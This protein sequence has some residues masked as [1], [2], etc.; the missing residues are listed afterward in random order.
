MRNPYVTYL[1]AINVG[2]RTVE[3]WCDDANGY[4][5][6]I[7]EDFLEHNDGIVYNP[8]TGDRE[9]LDAEDIR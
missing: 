9:I 4:I 7:E 3:L 6:G 2:G 5:F 1:Y 8:H